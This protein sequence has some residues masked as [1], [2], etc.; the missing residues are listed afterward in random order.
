M[1]IVIDLQ[2]SQTDSRFRGIGRY[3]L[4]LALGMARNAGDHEIWIVLNAALPA[5]IAD[6][7]RAF[8]GLVPPE[9]ICVFDPP[10]PLAEVLAEVERKTI[11]AALEASGGNK[12]SAARML[13]IS[14]ATLYQKITDY[15]LVSN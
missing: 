15:R 13:G 12:A 1:R 2:G 4:A 9:R 5:G 3:S 11:R 6:I 7:R 8:D 10:K 14:R